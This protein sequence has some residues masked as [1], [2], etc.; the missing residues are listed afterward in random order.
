M[1]SRVGA[2]F[3]VYSGSLDNAVDAMAWRVGMP[4]RAV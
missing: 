4:T 2:L 1:K 3:T